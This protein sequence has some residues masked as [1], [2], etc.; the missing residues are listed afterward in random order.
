MQQKQLAYLFL[1]DNMAKANVKIDY[2]VKYIWF[3][4]LINYPLTK[5]GFDVLVPDFCITYGKP[6]LAESK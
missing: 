3:L 1:W 4:M 6:Y 2:E 5:L